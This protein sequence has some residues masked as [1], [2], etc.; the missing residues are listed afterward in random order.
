M[1]LCSAAERSTYCAFEVKV[2][3]PAGAAISNIA[4]YLV[5]NM[6]TTLYSATTDANGI[7]RICDAPLEHLDIGVGSDL[8]GSV[9][10]QHLPP[11]WPE[12][13]HVFVTYVKTP[14][15]HFTFPSECRVLL[16]IQDH[17]GHP[18]RDALLEGLPSDE[19]VNASDV[20]GRVFRLVK[21]GKKFEG[22]ITKEGWLPARVTQVCEDDV[23]VKVVLR[24]Q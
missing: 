12:T 2:A 17:D 22:V 7:A 1:F 13:R 14:C 20:F 3:T 21:R 15:H 4:V 24:K 5:R 8:C 19:G 6:R 18:L 11:S 10:V 23:E 16:R 9:V